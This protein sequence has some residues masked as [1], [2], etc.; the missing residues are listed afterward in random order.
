MTS[1]A[2]VL[3]PEQRVASSQTTI[4]TSPVSGRGTWIDK[5]TA[6]NTTA[7]AVTISV[8]LVVT[9][10]SASDSNK[11]VSAKSLAAGETYTFPE[12]VGKFLAAGSF[13]SWIASAATSLTAGANGR[14]LT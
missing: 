14:E 4:Y 11:V 12:L 13:I 6:C 5:F 10:G 8:N 2:T 9:A 3:I 7:G 1:T